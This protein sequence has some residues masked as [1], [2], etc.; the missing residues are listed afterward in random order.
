[1]NPEWKP[2]SECTLTEQKEN[3]C[4]TGRDRTGLDRLACDG[5]SGKLFAPAEGGMN[6]GKPG[7]PEMLSKELAEAH[8]SFNCSLAVYRKL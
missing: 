8:S 3:G 7:K 4:S 5:D 2:T 1:M 6:A